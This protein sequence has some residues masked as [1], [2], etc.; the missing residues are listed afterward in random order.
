MPES[1]KKAEKMLEAFL[2]LYKINKEK[3]KRIILLIC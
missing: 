3:T 1:S 2:Y